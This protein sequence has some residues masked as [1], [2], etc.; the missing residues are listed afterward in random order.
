M[1]AASHFLVTGARADVA[2]PYL[3][4]FYKYHALTTPA[5]IEIEQAIPAFMGIGSQ[6]QMGLGM[7]TIAALL[8][9]RDRTDAK[10]VISGLALEPS[11]SINVAASM[12][13]GLLLVDATKRD[14]HGTPIVYQR[15][16][17]ETAEK[18]A[19][20]VVLVMPRVNGHPNTAESDRL[21]ALIHAQTT[22]GSDDT[23]QIVEQKLY[24]AVAEDDIEAFGA[25]LAEL[26][27]LNTAA[28]AAMSIDTSFTAE[29]EKIFA[30]M[31]DTGA[32][33]CG[34]SPTGHA[35]YALTRG[36]RA[37]IEMRKALR[38]VF[39]HSSGDMLATISQNVGIRVVEKKGTLQQRIYE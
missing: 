21:A 12:Q 37:T 22:A 36:A 19:W 15:A 9:E 1:Q 31:R 17:L 6:T 7:A 14:E 20:G 13:G 11:Q 5:E 34:K 18:T 2:A 26:Q 29:T 27:T 39:D 35:L 24:P 32:V 4:Q 30:I 28:L 10:F 23:A 8:N 3:E 33:V 38:R 16:E 25:G